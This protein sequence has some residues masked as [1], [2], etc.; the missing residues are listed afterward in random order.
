MSLSLDELE[1]LEA[2]LLNSNSME[3]TQIAM[4]NSKKLQDTMTHLTD[5][6]IRGYV[7][8][9]QKECYTLTDEGKKVLGIQPITKEVAK[10]IIAY[11][12]HDKVF[13]FHV[14]SDTPH[15]HHMHAHSLQDLSNKISRVDLKIIEF[16]LAN[17]DFEAWFKCL[18]DQE[19]TRKVAIVK[20]KNIVG[21]RLRLLLQNIIEHRCQ[22][23]MKLAEYITP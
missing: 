12:P 16:H 22:E 8:S 18:G 7:I 10:S 2:I 20:R 4:E 5:L 14:D 13:N 11:A 9:S 17:G 3:T 6:T 15:H 23:L 1:I 21:E 19:L